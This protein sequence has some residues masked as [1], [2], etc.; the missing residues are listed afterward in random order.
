MG[1]TIHLWSDREPVTVVEV[2]PFLSGAH[3]G[4][5]R[6]IKV[7]LDDW[8]IVRGSAQDGSATYEYT[9]NP[10]GPLRLFRRRKDGSWGR[11]G[12]RLTLGNRAKY[13]DPHM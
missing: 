8:K 5:A 11:R 13:I 2:T 7:R 6:M 9:P 4:A 3:E 10:D 1:G 12:D